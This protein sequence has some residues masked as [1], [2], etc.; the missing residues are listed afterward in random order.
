MPDRLEK[1]DCPGE[2]YII[3]ARS[4]GARVNGEEVEGLALAWVDKNNNAPSHVCGRNWAV[5]LATDVLK[6][7]QIASL[8][9][10]NIQDDED[11]DEE[12]E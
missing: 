8:A 1:C 7:R 12:E 9:I 6:G 4:C 5:S 2:I 11:E 10:S 3:E